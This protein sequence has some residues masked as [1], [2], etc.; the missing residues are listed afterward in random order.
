VGVPNFC[1]SEIVGV[2][3]FCGLISF[4]IF[5][6][7]GACLQ[8]EGSRIQ[9]YSMLQGDWIGSGVVY[10]EEDRS[11]ACLREGAHADFVPYEH[12]A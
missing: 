8:E 3:N 2:L 7:Q 12:D 11:L 10:L 5:S 4:L 1:W 6:L 9:V